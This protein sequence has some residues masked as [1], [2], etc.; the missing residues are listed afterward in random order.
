MPW[1]GFDQKT[2]RTGISLSY[3]R[4]IDN[5]LTAMYNIICPRSDVAQKLSASYDTATHV[6]L[7]IC[8][9]EMMQRKWTEA[10]MKFVTD[11]LKKHGTNIYLFGTEF[12]M[13]I[14]YLVR[15]QRHTSQNILQE[16]F[17]QQV[18]K[19]RPH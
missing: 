16:M 8:L 15:L 10:K 14:K 18:L 4:T 9:I 3:T 13:T 7:E 6:V 2:N 5:I 19:T 11:L 1:G 12:E 17:G